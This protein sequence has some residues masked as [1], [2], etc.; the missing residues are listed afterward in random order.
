VLEGVAR[1]VLESKLKQEIEALK[2]EVKTLK[3]TVKRLT[4]YNNSATTIRKKN[5]NSWRTTGG[6]NSK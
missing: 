2:E 6:G 3:A 4:L 1:S 5:S